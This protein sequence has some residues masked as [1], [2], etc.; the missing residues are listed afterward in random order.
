M[1]IDITRL[2]EHNKKRPPTKLEVDALLTEI[3]TLRADRDAFRGL[4]ERA[5][6]AMRAWKSMLHPDEEALL[7]EIDDNLTARKP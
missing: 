2:R 3:E 6:S 5:G 1:T 4:L 7:D